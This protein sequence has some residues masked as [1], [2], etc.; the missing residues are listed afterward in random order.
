MCSPSLAT[1]DHQLLLS[2]R[3]VDNKSLLC[4]STT[5][6]LAEHHPLRYLSKVVKL[7]PCGHLSVWQT[8]S[9][10]SIE[11]QQPYQIKVFGQILHQIMPIE[12]KDDVMQPPLDYQL[13]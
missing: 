6:R 12:I 5:S 13:Y 10:E 7:P 3:Y 9:L 4:A 2:S 8:H 11:N 1:M